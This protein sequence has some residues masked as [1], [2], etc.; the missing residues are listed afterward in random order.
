MAASINIETQGLDAMVAVLTPKLF[1]QR[2]SAGLRYA[3]KSVKKESAKQIGSRYRL[4]SSRIK[5]DI[6]SLRVADKEIIVT[7]NRRPPTLRAYGARALSSGGIS[8]SVF[9]SGRLR[10]PRGFF[11]PI[12]PSPGIPFIRTGSG[13]SAIKTLYGPSVGSI[14]V[15][16]SKFGKDIREQT[17]KTIQTQFIKGVEREISRRARGR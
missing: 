17:T 9:K 1:Q 10:Q 3:S 7:F 15:G 5:G 16:D 6:K 14:F 11:L 4:A 8:Y 12:G 13:R 2:V